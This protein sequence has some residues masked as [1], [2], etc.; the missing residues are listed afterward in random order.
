M[1]V[2][3]KEVAN[4]DSITKIISYTYSVEPILVSDKRFSMLICGIML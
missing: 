4:N 2:N 1:H 3:L